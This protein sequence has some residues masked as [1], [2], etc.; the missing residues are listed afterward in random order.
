MGA[1]TDN[2][3]DPEL[4]GALLLA[5]RGQAYFSRKLHELHDAQFSE[6]SLLPGWSRGTVAA[7][8]GLNARAVARLV[9]WAATGIETPM[10]SSDTQREEEIELGTTL[11]T[12][13]IR[14]LSDH[15]AVHLNVEWRDLPQEAWSHEIRTA[16]G[17]VVR[18]SET[19]WMRMREVWLHAVDLNNGGRVDDFPI[20]VQDKLLADLISVWR[21]KRT[22]ESVNVILE[23]TDRGTSLRISEEDEPRTIVAIGRVA[24][25]VA[26]GTGRG[27]KGVLTPDG[28]AAPPAPPWL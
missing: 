27:T 18:A 4:A 22:P 26:W 15:A 24:D 6:P 8:V 23:P 19:V 5:R 11:P 3:T 21:R 12:Q 13:A 25:L 2:V 28:D 7:H 20:E 16:Q 14:N 17:R 1:R 10:Y 9:E